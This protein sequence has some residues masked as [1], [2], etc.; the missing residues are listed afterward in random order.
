MSKKAYVLLLT[1]LMATQ[2]QWANNATDSILQTQVKARK[3][4]EI[5]ANF[6]SGYYHQDG[7]NSAVTGGIGTEKL[8]DFSNV[9]I[10]NVPPRFGSIGE[11]NGRVRHLHFRFDRQY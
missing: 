10:V 5:D 9:F 11:F 7:N 2:Y 8:T 3:L 4:K 1:L 6:L